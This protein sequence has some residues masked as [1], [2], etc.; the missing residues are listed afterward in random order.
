MK[1]ATHHLRCTECGAVITKDDVSSNFRCPQ[2]KGLYEV[3]YPW[4]DA[5]V[6]HL[7]GASVEASSLLPNPSALRWLWQERRSSSMAIDQ[8]GVWRF[9]DLLPIVDDLEKVV[10]LR[11]GNTP[12]YD[13]PRCAKAAGIDW[14]LAKHQGMN[15]TG[16]FKDTGMTAALS[17]AAQRGFE[18]V[19]CASTGNTSAA[20]AA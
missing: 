7:P 13:L 19:A 2:C 16:S 4:S 3:V 9:R 1:V 6:G 20:M 15:P 17:V 12:L 8:S 18:W 5:K 10:T 14:L 11:E